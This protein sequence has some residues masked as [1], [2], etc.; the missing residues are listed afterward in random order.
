MP[1]TA[2]DLRAWIRTFADQVAE[3]RAYLTKLDSAIGDG[4]HGQNLNRGLSHAAEGLDNG[5]DDLPS[6]MKSV[7]MSLISK[8]GGASGPLYGTFFMDAG[9]AVGERPE[10]DVAG[11]AEL[12]RAGL[13]G[14]Q[15]R[16]KAEPG[17]KT[18]VD[19]LL[20][21]V[22]ALEEAAENG[23]ALPT[24][25]TNAKAAAEEGMK[26]TT[27]LQARKG[28]AS[29]LGERSK[30]HQDPGATSSYYLVAAAAD[31]FGSSA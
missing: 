17:D 31:T 28:R 19:A 2:A 16:G 21:A 11:V 9:K 24:A 10:L 25:L 12:F 23:E 14:V 4:D 22:E 26:A 5:N 30:G 13:A 20:P 15:R 6:T 27:P 1:V 8:T 29:Y 7:A 3:E 18:M